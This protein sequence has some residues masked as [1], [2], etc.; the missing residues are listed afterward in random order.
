MEK[1]RIVIEEDE[2][3]TRAD[4]EDHLSTLGY[5]VLA[6][7]PSGE[8]AIKKAEQFKPD[9]ILMD[10][11]LSDEMDGIDAAKIIMEVAKSD[12]MKTCSLTAVEAMEKLSMVKRIQAVL[13]ENDCNVS[14]LSIDIPE[15]GHVKIS[16]LASSQESKKRILDTLKSMRSI[17]NVQENI[18]ILD[19]DR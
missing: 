19:Y 2:P 10:I 1:A 8:E 6:A 12:Q 13:M 16:G 7:I 11:L 17:E 5:D 3:I 18:G 9:L 14:T 4:I 15:K